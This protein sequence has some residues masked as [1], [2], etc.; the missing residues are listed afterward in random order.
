VILGRSGRDTLPPSTC[1][2][3]ALESMGKGLSIIL[4]PNILKVVLVVGHG[5]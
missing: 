5:Q 4:P 1:Q 2:L 3:Q